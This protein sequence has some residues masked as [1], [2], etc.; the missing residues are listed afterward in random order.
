MF[1]RTNDD[2]HYLHRK[3]HL[4]LYW[5]LNN[6]CWIS[7][8]LFSD[9]L[10][11]LYYQKREFVKINTCTNVPAISKR[12]VVIFLFRWRFC[13]VH[14]SFLIWYKNLFVLGGLQ[15]MPD[16]L[17]G[18]YKLITKLFIQP[19]FI[20]LNLLLLNLLRSYNW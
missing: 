15:S 9:I 11:L 17:P 6:D 10:W 7:L 16:I 4:Y 3:L 5:L 14:I 13:R 2:V 18:T 19:F 1:N 12:F 8:F 20:L